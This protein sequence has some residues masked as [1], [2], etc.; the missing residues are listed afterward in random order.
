MPKFTKA[1]DAMA[2]SMMQDT[3][4]LKHHIGLVL[5]TSIVIIWV[6]IIVINSVSVPYWSIGFF[7]LPYK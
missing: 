3:P 1:N 7:F 2:P 6:I 5:T 4:N